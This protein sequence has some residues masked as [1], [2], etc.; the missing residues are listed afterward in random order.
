MACGPLVAYICFKVG[1]S[2]MLQNPPPT[3]HATHA[4]N[5]LHQRLA[6]E[7]YSTY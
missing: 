4:I 6:M 2:E 7:I 3:T 5:E 1:L